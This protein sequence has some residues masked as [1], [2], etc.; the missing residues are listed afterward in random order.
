VSRKFNVLLT[1]YE[2]VLNKHDRSKLES[3]EWHYIIVDEGTVA[4]GFAAESVMCVCRASHEEHQVQV[5][6][7]AQY[8]LSLPASV[9]ERHFPAPVFKLFFY[10]RKKF[11]SFQS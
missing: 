8:T 9:S 3:I 5:H 2:Y 1:T 4:T 7:G 10:C 11:F 6:R